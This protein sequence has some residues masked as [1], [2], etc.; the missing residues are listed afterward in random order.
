MAAEAA[1]LRTE[2]DAIEYGLTDSRSPGT[3]SIKTKGLE[4]APL[5]VPNPLTLILTYPS[6][7]WPLDC[8]TLTPGISPSRVSAELVTGLLANTSPET[9]ET[10]PVRSTF[11][12]VP[13]PTTTTSFK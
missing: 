5:N 11:L 1:S 7:G 8:T 4:P 6:P 9:D 2:T 12:S 10:D 13:Y 3:P